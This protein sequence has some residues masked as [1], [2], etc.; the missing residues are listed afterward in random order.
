MKKK[1]KT[2]II[3]V[4]FLLNIL[5]MA[6]TAN[7][8]NDYNSNGYNAV[9]SDGIVS[10]DMAFSDVITSDNISEDI[11]SSNITVTVDTY[12][13]RPIS[14]NVEDYIFLSMEETY[15]WLAPYGFCISRDPDDGANWICGYREDRP[16]LCIIGFKYGETGQLEYIGIND[17]GDAEEEWTFYGMNCR[18][19]VE[20]MKN[21][22]RE[23]SA[24][25]FG[26]NMVLYGSGIGLE[27]LGI[28]MIDWGNGSDYINYMD[29]NINT[30]YV[31]F[32][33]NITCEIESR[34]AEFATEDGTTFVIEYPVFVSEGEDIFNAMNE[35]L[36]QLVEEN[37]EAL[38][39]V[40]NRNNILYE[41]ECLE[42]Q[43]ISISFYRSGDYHY[44]SLFTFNYDLVEDD[45]MEMPDY[46]Q[47][48]L[49]SHREMWE[50]KGPYDILNWYIN[51]M[52]VHVVYYNQ[53]S[54]EEEGA[55][56]W[57]K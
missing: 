6:C 12:E 55:D 35:R 50:E 54:G 42:T 27:K 47:E 1:N 33:Q 46:L 57:R 49:E 52:Q 43:G 26:H 25:I 20:E 15:A 31:D 45:L 28:G 36:L 3:S 44:Q 38:R 21:R 53:I 9:S 18:M 34:E 37:G 23:Q 40:N 39:E 2:V 29:I 4:I 51:P 24:V 22:V 56:F 14:Y 32:L 16:E 41:I 7:Q 30:N 5:L 8:N 13:D 17:F 48:D 10:E 11:I 19:T